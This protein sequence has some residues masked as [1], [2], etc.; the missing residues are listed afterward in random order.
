MKLPMVLP[1]PAPADD[2][3]PGR[4]HN[5]HGRRAPLPHPLPCPVHQDHPSLLRAVTT[6]LQLAAAAQGTVT[7]CTCAEPAWHAP[8]AD[9]A[10][11]RAIVLEC[12]SALEQLHAGLADA[13]PADSLSLR[14]Q[15][16]EA[17]DELSQ[18]RDR[19]RQAL[20]LALHDTLTE[21]PNRHYLSKQ[22]HRVLDTLASTPSSLALLFID[23]DGFKRVNDD[24][25]HAMGDELLRI[26]ASRLRHAVR[27]EDLVCRLGGDEF[28]LLLSSP[29]SR[30]QLAHLAAELVKTVSAP[31]D[32]GGARVVVQPSIGI[33][34]CPVEGSS[35]LTLMDRADTAMYRAKRSHSGYAFHES[36]LQA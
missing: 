20:H 28:V 7:S 33:A 32:L 30:E 18:T 3:D 29:P 10:L 1:V 6:R 8:A 24:H 12:A 9:L 17:R 21:L 35:A 22:L 25:G 31:I 23:L 27:S 16:G 13:D 11:L 19:E 26:V 36:Q 4:Q 5:G 2:K 15:L 34:L 14:L